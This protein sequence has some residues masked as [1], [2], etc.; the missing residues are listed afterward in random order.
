MVLLLPS[1]FRFFIIDEKINFII[2]TFF[3]LIGLFISPGILNLFWKKV[4]KDNSSQD[5]FMLA[6]NKYFMSLLKSYVNNFVLIYFISVII[7][8]I[9]RLK[10]IEVRSFVF[11]IYTFSLSISI[12]I[13]YVRNITGFK[14]VK[15]TLKFIYKK[16]RDSMLLLVLVLLEKLINQLTIFINSS[17]LLFISNFASVFLSLLTILIGFQII[18][19]RYYD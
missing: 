15:E 2:F 3:L 19:E 11:Y 13:I 18:K 7:F 8:F 17:L 5:N 12:P 14:N 16:P 9:L 1:I 4:K 6:V 10:Y